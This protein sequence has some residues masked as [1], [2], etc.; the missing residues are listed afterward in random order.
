[1]QDQKTRFDKLAEMLGLKT[2]KTPQTD[3]LAAQIPDIKKALE[4]VRVQAQRERKD[5]RRGGCGCGF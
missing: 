1:M 2:A 5:E 3:D 4:P